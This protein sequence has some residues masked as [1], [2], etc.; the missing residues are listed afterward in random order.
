MAGRLSF[1]LAYGGEGP[2]FL[3]LMHSVGFLE[4]VLGCI[5]GMPVDMRVKITKTVI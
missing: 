1:A 5:E 4:S 2:L 3:G